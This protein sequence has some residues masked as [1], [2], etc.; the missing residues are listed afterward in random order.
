VKGTCEDEAETKMKLNAFI[1]THVPRA[2]RQ[3]RRIHTRCRC[4][5]L[6]TR[7]TSSLNNKLF[8]VGVS[9]LPQTL[10]YL[11]STSSPHPVESFAD[12][13]DLLI[14]NHNVLHSILPFLSLRRAP[15][16]AH[17][18][19]CPALS[20]AHPRLPRPVL[21]STRT[22]LRRPQTSNNSLPPS[23]RMSICRENTTSHALIC[24]SAFGSP[25]HRHLALIRTTHGEVAR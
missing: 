12:I 13:F 16:L 17:T 2:Q 24:R 6:Y 8:R 1:P 10:V 15:L 7:T 23:L 20:I 18:F 25:F 22:S 11:A 4:K 5:V 19:T 3:S 21:A 14:C 9:Q